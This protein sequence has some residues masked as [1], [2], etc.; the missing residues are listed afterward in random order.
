MVD[1]A[2][3][4]QADENHGANMT[5]VSGQNIQPRSIL[6]VDDE[7]SG[8]KSFH[9]QDVVRNFYD[10]VADTTDPI[11][12]DLWDVA[13]AIPELGADDWDGDQA[14]QYLGGNAAVS[15]VLLSEEFGQIA[16][17][18]LKSLLG[19]FTE[20]AKRVS[21]LKQMFAAAFPA[22]LFDLQ[23]ISSPRPNL[24][25]IL[26]YDA[27]FLDLF[28]DHAD[29]T[30]VDT[31]QNYLRELSRQA[32]AAILP[33]IILMSSHGEL[34]EHKRNF[35]LNSQISA[36]GLMV[37]PK[38]TLGMPEFG[39]TG[40]NLAFKQLD[41]QKSVA[42]SMRAFIGSWLAALDEAK[43]KTAQTLWNLDA[44]AM[45]H[46]HLA[47]VRDADPYDEHINE[48]LSRE[49]LF[50]V[51]AKPSV[52]Q[53]IDELDKC[54]RGLLTPEGEGQIENRLIAPMTDIDTARAFMS[55]FTWFGS[56]LPE[57]FLSDECD[58]AS[59]ISR[60]L[61]F[62]SVLHCGELSHGG[63]CLV[64]ITQQCDLNAIS[65][66]KDASRTVSFVTADII[67]LQPSDNPVIK[68]SEFFAKNLRVMQADSLRE[69]DLHVKAG[70]LFALPFSEFLDKARS[71]GWRIVG[72]LRSDISNHIVA[73]VTNQMSR[74]ASQRMIR[75]GLLRAKL[76]L[77]ARGFQNNPISLTDGHSGGGSEK[78]FSLSIEEK[79]FSFQ[80]EACIEIAL[81]LTHHL[82]T[83]SI[84]LDADALVTALS[85]EWKSGVELVQGLKIKVKETDN[86]DQALNE[87]RGEAIG[88]LG[89]LI[90]VREK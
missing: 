61:P 48:L 18:A 29:H 3:A 47:A 42:H 14:A 30:P 75:P 17:D 9:V 53:S 55:H 8:F 36:A 52:A 54:F 4:D 38:A 35:S 58:A 12:N 44:S 27:V 72:R 31:V 60:S 65:R 24:A 63:K 81:W 11:F 2:M 43:E 90:V 82:A 78:I 88:S 86:L 89:Q 84:Q 85:R 26:Q 37:L 62:G 15:I 1:N 16:S 49:H 50:H 74:P 59:R 87:I 77:Q 79:K 23:F 51:E 64:H 46:I 19:P 21:E 69:F 66:N 73:A 57:N 13:K 45:Q 67:E 5:S 32:G 20:R 28:L 25:S 10:H 80:D 76:F 83:I 41:R 33:P 68:T 6:V 70:E 7:L 56:P 34:K 40:L 71:E 22:P 39:A